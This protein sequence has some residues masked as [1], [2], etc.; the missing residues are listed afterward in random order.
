MPSF[1]PSMGTANMADPSI[2]VDLVEL[3]KLIWFGNVM[4]TF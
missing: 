4:Y 1:F 2:S 3:P